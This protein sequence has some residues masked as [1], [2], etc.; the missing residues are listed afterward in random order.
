MLERPRQPGPVRHGS[1]HRVFATA[2]WISPSSAGGPGGKH[3]SFPCPW[4][5]E[6]ASRCWSPGW[7]ARPSGETFC[8]TWL[9]PRPRSPSSS[10]AATGYPTPWT[11]DTLVLSCSYSGNTEE[12][13]ATFEQA[14][15]QGAPIIAVSGGGALARE[16]QARSL[17]FFQIDYQGEPR[18]ALGYS[19]IVPA[20][21]LSKLGLLDGES[22]GFEDAFTLPWTPCC[23]PLARMFPYVGQPGQAAGPS[24]A[25]PPDSGLWLRHILGRVPAV[26]DPV[27]RELQGARLLRVPARSTP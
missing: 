22:I 26:E 19:F 7:A 8:R 16:A 21:L 9:P 5:W 4:T 2:C 24:P 1:I 23:P 13:L 12:T 15:S 27:Q 10:S 20:V 11:R 14:S 6:A 18:S 17:P 3:R 25:Q